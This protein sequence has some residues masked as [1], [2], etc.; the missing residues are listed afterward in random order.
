MIHYPEFIKPDLLHL[1]PLR[2]RWYGVMYIL[3]FFAGRQILRHLCKTRWL[4]MAG[5]KVDDFLIA[6]FIGMLVGARL[7]YMLVYYRATE[8]DPFIWYKTPFAVWE[9]G[10]A[11]HGGALGMFIAIVYFARREKVPYWN[12]AD[13]LVLAAPVGLFLGRIGNFINAELYGRPTDV[14]WAMAFP[15]RDFDETVI[16]YTEPRHPSQLYEAMTEGLLTLAILWIAKRFIKNQGVLSGLGISCYAVF[17]FIVEFFREKDAQLE[18]YFGWM[19][20][21]QILCAVMLAV[22]LGMMAFNARRA[23]PIA[24]PEPESQSATT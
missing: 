4:R 16:G 23:V 20:M 15:I 5:D 1:G 9:G 13:A 14:P 17:R 3:G 11:F 7:I 6:L 10:L 24:G 22:G 12:L 8:M 18:Y 21:G 19:T 2:V